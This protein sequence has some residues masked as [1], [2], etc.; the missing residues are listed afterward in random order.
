MSGRE[1]AYMLPLVI[2]SLWIGIYPKPFI[3]YI[4][5]P[6]NAVVRQIRP[7][8]PIPGLPATPQTSP[9]PVRAAK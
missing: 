3:A 7:D 8:Y 6:V 9:V 2:L 5:K 1:W 4:Q